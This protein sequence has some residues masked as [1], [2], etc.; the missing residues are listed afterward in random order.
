MTNVGPKSSL[1][2]LKVKLEEKYELKE[3]ARLG[4]G[5][6]DDK[7]AR[8]LNRVVRW[9]DH[10]LEYGADPRQDERLMRERAAAQ[11]RRRA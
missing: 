9:T 7:E 11:W 4:P 6:K 3:S 5:V 2:W 1:D 8:V 10:G